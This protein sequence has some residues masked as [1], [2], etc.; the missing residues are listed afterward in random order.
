MNWRAVLVRAGVLATLAAAPA[1]ADQDRLK[2][3]S[4]AVP[5]HPGLTYTDLVRQ[6]VPDLG[7][8]GD[9][10]RPE[11]HFRTPPRH[12]AG[13]EFQGEPA[14]PAVLGFIEDK[15]ILVGGKKRIALLADLGGK[16]SR[17]E[18]LALLMLFDD[19][20]RTP[21]LLDAADVGIDK[22]TGFA[23]QAVLPLGPGDSALVTW[24]E[25]NSAQLTMGGYMIVSPVGDRLAMVAQ[26]P[27]TSASLCSWL[28]LSAARLRCG[29]DSGNGAPDPSQPASPW[30]AL[31][32][33]S[34]RNAALRGCPVLGRRARCGCNS[35]GNT[36]DPVLPIDEEIDPLFAG[37]VVSNVP[38]G[39]HQLFD[40][41]KDD[42][43]VVLT[44]QPQLLH[45]FSR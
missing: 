27:L 20:G 6:A 42:Q 28:S 21:R 2:N 15:R 38:V 31:A 16:E 5:G 14:E 29:D 12:L 25:H 17:I 19:E 37:Y 45:H 3:A 23:N 4:D 13:E 44:C 35:G 1:I 10:R 11:G 34:I 33:R 40:S 22:D 36:I 26:L 24:S 7:V 32:I 8:T 43:L 9:D 41:R 30:F 18:G 39:R